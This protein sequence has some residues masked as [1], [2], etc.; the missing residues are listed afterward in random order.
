MSALKSLISRAFCNCICI[1]TPISKAF[2]YNDVCKLD[3]ALPLTRE[4]HPLTI[5]YLYI[6]LYHSI[7]YRIV[8]N[9]QPRLNE[10]IYVVFQ[11]RL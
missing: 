3:A 7:R 5:L 9:I 6:I 2:Y 11:A 8:L 4:I 10:Q 1:Y